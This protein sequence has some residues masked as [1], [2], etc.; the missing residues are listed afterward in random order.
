VFG[1]ILNTRT[2][3]APVMVVRDRHDHK[4]TGRIVVSLIDFFSRGPH[5]ITYPA[6]T[7]LMSVLRRLPRPS[8]GHELANSF[9]SFQRPRWMQLPLT[10]SVVDHSLGERLV[11]LEFERENAIRLSDAHISHLHAQILGQAYAYMAFIRDGTALAYYS[12]DFGLKIWDIADLAI[13]H[14]HSTRKLIL[15]RMR[16]RW[17]GL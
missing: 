8:L 10:Y 14:R 4:I 11:A 15:R 6:E 12:D 3:L 1:R 17:W 2:Q 13:D 5:L 9:P 16:D 7:P